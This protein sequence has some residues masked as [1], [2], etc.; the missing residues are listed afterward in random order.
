M[1]FA[2]RIAKSLDNELCFGVTKEGLSVNTVVV[3]IKDDYAMK[4]KDTSNTVSDKDIAEEDFDKSPYNAELKVSRGGRMAKI[5]NY[6]IDTDFIRTSNEEST[7]NLYFF[8]SKINERTEAEHVILLGY[9]LIKFKKTRNKQNYLYIDIICAKRGLGGKILDS[10]VS[11][12]NELKMA[13][14]ELTALDKPIAFY[15]HKKFD[16]I[17]GKNSGDLE[18]PLGLFK[19]KKDGQ[20]NQSVHIDKDLL[21]N[22]QF[23]REDGTVLDTNTVLSTLGFN[24]RHD[25]MSIDEFNMKRDA[26]LGKLGKKGVVTSLKGVKLDK[27]LQENGTTAPFMELKLPTGEGVRTK[28]R[29]KGSKRKHSS[30]KGKGKG[31]GN[32]KGT[33]RANKKSGKSTKNETRRR[34]SSRKAK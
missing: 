2:L 32:G 10:V 25:G 16:F 30:T 19:T 6:D 9:V 18:H 5:C 29:T 15:R 28:Q 17:K 8:N 23:K 26:A 14:V 1:S 33:R 11:L 4:K 7:L 22:V 21:P 31:K 27:T 13:K 12:A 3:K 20:G 34:R 24:L